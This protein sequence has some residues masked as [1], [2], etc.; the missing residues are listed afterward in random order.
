VVRWEPEWGG[1]MS[2]CVGGSMAAFVNLVRWEPSGFVLASTLTSHI[3]RAS[4]L[5]VCLFVC[6][7]VLVFVF[8]SL[9]SHDRPDVT[10]ERRRPGVRHDQS[11]D[12]VMSGPSSGRT[13]RVSSPLT[14]SNLASLGGRDAWGDP[15]A[16]ASRG[17]DDFDFSRIFAT[18]H[19]GT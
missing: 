14:A 18:A 6:L 15:G 8:V 16:S 4:L 5:H 19:S 9:F 2:V 11:S 13:L 3:S 12:V 7:F 10:D 1:N 17:L